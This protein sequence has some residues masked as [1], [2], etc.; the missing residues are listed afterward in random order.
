[1]EIGEKQKIN[2]SNFDQSKSEEKLLKIK[3][4]PN[5]NEII[6]P[7]NFEEDKCNY[8][9]ITKDKNIKLPAEFLQYAC[10]D[11]AKIPKVIDFCSEIPW[12]DVLEA[13]KFYI[14]RCLR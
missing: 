10:E 5:T 1:M 6:V 7:F 3:S 9:L 12:D 14:P 13:L 2:S 4:A 8:I 11:F